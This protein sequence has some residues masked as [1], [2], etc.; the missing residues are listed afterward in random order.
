MPLIELKCQCCGKSFDVYPYRATTAK[1]CSVACGSKINKNGL[2]TGEILMKNGYIAIRVN[3]KYVYK[4]RWMMEQL[5]GRKLM[6]NEIV[7]HRDGN[8]QNN[9]YSNLKRM[10][11]KEHDKIETTRRW[12]E[13]DR[14][15][16]DSEKCNHPRSGRKGKNKL[17]QRPKPCSYHSE[18]NHV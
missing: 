12:G 2:K 18:V 5:L 16:L 13:G 17:C 11:K 7:H 9:T 10:N 1:Y 15:F 3:G 4:H 8:K 14:F 6:P